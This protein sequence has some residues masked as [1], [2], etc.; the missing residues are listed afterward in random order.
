MPPANQEHDAPWQHFFLMLMERGLSGI[1]LTK[2]DGFPA[3]C[4]APVPITVAARY[5]IATTPRLQIKK[6][7]CPVGCAT[8]G[9][10]VPGG[11]NDGAALKGG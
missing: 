11:D 3:R 5:A 10:A 7:V 2:T 6:M 1:T 9:A 4:V 8:P